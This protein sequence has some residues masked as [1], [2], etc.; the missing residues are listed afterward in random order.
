MNTV[1]F[2]VKRIKV[3]P[4]LLVL[5]LMAF[6][7]NLMSEGRKGV[8]LLVMKT[9]A[10]SV[11]GELIAV[12]QRTLLIKEAGTQADVS[13]SIGDVKYIKIGGKSYTAI[14]AL[15]GLIGGGVLGI[16]LM[17]NKG[18]TP[19]TSWVVGIAAL[20]GGA[21]AL[22]GALTGAASSKKGSEIQVEGKNDGEIKAILEDLRSKARIP[23]AE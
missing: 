6:S 14:G 4:F 8:E 15:F 10:K 12:K 7:G 5:S 9:D 18:G 2:R 20:F 16:I 17:N 13:I 11:S 1:R 23:N 19:P 22:V 21:G 3:A